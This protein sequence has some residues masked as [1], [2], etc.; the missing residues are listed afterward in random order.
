ME[1][2]K[3][4]WTPHSSDIF[5]PRIAS[6]LQIYPTFTNGSQDQPHSL[7]NIYVPNEIV[8]DPTQFKSVMVWMHGGGYVFGDGA[9]YDATDL[10]LT[11]DVIV[12]T[13][14][15]RLGVLGFLSNMDS[16]LPGNYGL[17]DQR[18]AI[19]WVHDNIKHFGGDAGSVTIFGESAGGF[20][21]SLHALMPQNK[22]LFQRVIL[23]SGACATL[24]ST[25]RDPQV[26]TRAIY[27]AIGCS[28][29]DHE[30]TLDSAR[31]LE[32]LRKPSWDELVSMQS[33]AVSDIGIRFISAFLPVVDGVLLRKEPVDI[34]S[35]ESSPEVQFF[36]S[37]DIIAGNTNLEH[38]GIAAIASAYQEQFMFDIKDGIPESVAC[39]VLAGALAIE[40][41]RDIRARSLICNLLTYSDPIS[42]GLSLITVSSVIFEVGPT[43]KILDLHSTYSKN[44]NASTYQYVFS[45]EANQ[46]ILMTRPKWL[47]YQGSEHFTDIFAIF[48]VHILSDMFKE[49]FNADFND[50]RKSM[51]SSLTTFAK[52]G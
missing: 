28:E 17:M 13:F 45:Y 22:G 37:L 47:Q 41:Y 24:L 25:A 8:G 2:G 26:V 10:A 42:I 31:I 11:G 6:L 32:C 40:G 29:S 5:V 4:H 9:A 36:S 3:E 15:Y 35:D 18:M 1:N 44:T 21:S 39:G 27:N 19:Q 43:V 49:L 30:E 16:I 50:L 12:V 52:T 48:G 14:N 46:G 23:Q 38:A 20:S 7:K 34:L 51:L 33:Y